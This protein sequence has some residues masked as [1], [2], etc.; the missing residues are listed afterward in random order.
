MSMERADEIVPYA[1]APSQDPAG[2]LS[3]GIN[4]AC[5][6]VRAVSDLL[7][8]VKAATTKQFL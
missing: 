2:L 8:V 1:E 7:F 5:N 3:N 6:E 4:G